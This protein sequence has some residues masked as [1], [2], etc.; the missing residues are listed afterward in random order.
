M[1]RF[2]HRVFN[3]TLAAKAA[4]AGAETVAGLTLAL[5]FGRRLHEAAL[6]L[7]VHELSQNPTDPLA[8]RLMPVLS[9]G[10]H[11]Q[12]WATYLLGHGLIKLAVLFA[13]WRRWLWAYPLAM[14]VMGLFIIWQMQ[15]YA[16]DHSPAM[17]ALS[18]LDAVMIWLTWREW[19]AKDG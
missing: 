5:P 4:L 8:L 3:G 11:G 15:R 6:S 7:T 12:F 17:L 19:Q 2:L 16:T 14:V 18:L 13:L 1:S 10:H 9:G